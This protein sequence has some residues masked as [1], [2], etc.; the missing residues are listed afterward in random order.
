MQETL[1]EFLTVPLTSLDSKGFNDSFGL[2]FGLDRYFR[3]IT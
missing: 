2:T 3:I 1:K